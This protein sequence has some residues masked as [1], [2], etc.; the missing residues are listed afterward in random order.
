MG[1][2]FQGTV[3]QAI[4]NDAMLAWNGLTPWSGNDMKFSS[5]TELDVVFD[6]S[7]F[8]ISLPVKGVEPYVVDGEK[9]WAKEG[10]YFVF[11]PN[12]HASASGKF[13]DSVDGFCFFITVET[14]EEVAH[15]IR[16]PMDNLLDSPF[17]YSWQ[18]ID[19]ISQAYDMRGNSFGQFLQNLKQ[20]LIKAKG[21][22]IIDWE[23][24]YFEFAKEFILGHHQINNQVSSLEYVRPSTRI[25]LFKRIS[26]V[27]SYILDNPK[28]II[29]L[30]E[31]QRVGCLSKF[32]LIRLYK[33]VYGCTPYQQIL[34]EK[35][36]LAKKMLVNNYSPTQIA[37]ELSFADR[38]TFS[39][40][41]KRMVGVPPS[42]FAKGE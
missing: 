24:F 10:E 6:A 11:N 1:N 17:L 18:K 5:V 19:F 13:N 20:Q 41:F 27:H 40:T 34:I 4:P 29:S 38:R 15:A 23:L 14:L 28:R 31:L 21:G 39:R 33:S 3:K 8:H 22:S 36:R 2:Y 16:N 42:S 9:H 7:R 25:E 26:K 30:D 12:Q 35:I 32:Q 37:D